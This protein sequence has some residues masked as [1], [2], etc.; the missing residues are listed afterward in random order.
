METESGSQNPVPE[1]ANASSEPLVCAE[2]SVP[3]AEGQDF[4]R[5]NGGT[6]C[7]ACFDRLT[8]ELQRA[9]AAQG[10]NVNWP[11][12]ALGGLLGAA[13]GVLVWWGFTV[14]T[15]IA[16][17]IVAIVIGFAVGKGVVMLSGG[18]RH[19]G[20]Q[21]MSAVIA[22]VAFF[23]A[24]YLVDRSFILQYAANHGEHAVIPLLPIPAL[25]E[26]VI[27][28][29][30]RPMDLVFLAIVLYEAWKI[31]KPARLRVSTK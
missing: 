6:F 12:A 28:A 2:C 17:G 30:F 16:F 29:G 15:Q 8:G 23:Y 21:V 20:L 7:R 22:A 26:K 19:V 9:V 13:G 24:S 31:P 10:Q 18:S 1:A 5:T 4:E 14:A 3:I 27:K 25:F 11:M